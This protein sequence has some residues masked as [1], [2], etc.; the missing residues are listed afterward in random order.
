[1]FLPEVGD[2]VMV[3]FELG[4]L[5]RPY[6]LG[7]IVNNRSGYQLGG[8]SVVAK[9][10]SASVQWRGL[11]TPSGARLAFHDEVPAPGRVDQAEILLGSGDG[12]LTLRI[13]QVAGA[14]ALRCLPGQ[15]TRPGEKGRIVIECGPGGAIDVVAGSGGAV[16]IDGGGELTLKAQQLNLQGTRISVNGTGPVELKGKPIKLN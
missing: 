2:E 6:V 7:G 15:V 4:D 14:V 9:G 10:N 8:P 1:M 16:T 13:D 3:G 11:A 5:H 12:N